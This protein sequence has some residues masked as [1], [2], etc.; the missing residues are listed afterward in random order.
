VKRDLVIGKTVHALD[1]VDLERGLSESICRLARD[2][3]IN[4]PKLSHLSTIRPVRAVRPRGTPSSTSSWHVLRVNEDEAAIE[5]V[6][7]VDPDG[8]ATDRDFVGRVN[9]HDGITGRVN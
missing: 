6:G 1:D 7:G 2:A 4:I 9:F 8:L 5:D 3:L